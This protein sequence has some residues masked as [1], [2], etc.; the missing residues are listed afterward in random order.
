MSSTAVGAFLDDATR[1]GV[2][3]NSLMVWRGGAVAAEG[4][5]WPYRP[6]L[7]HMMHSATKSFLSAGVG[8]AL[9]EGRFALTDKA[10]SFFDP[11]QLPADVGENLRAMTV[12]DLLTQTSGHSQGASGSVWRFIKTSWV[13]EF[14]KIPVTYRPGAVFKYTSANSFLLSAILSQTTG[15][16]A[17]A[18]ITPRLLEP[19]GIT[20]LSWDVGP[21]GINPGGNG[22]SCRTADL[23]KLAILHLR[24]GVWD[25]RRVL[26]A[27]WVGRATRPQRGNPHGYH[28]W[29]G[30]GGAF[31]AY[32]IF[33][34]FAVAFPEHDAIVV[35]TASAP[36][37][38]ETLRSLIWHHF[39]RAFQT[40]S[41]ASNDEA[42]AERLSGLRVLDPIARRESP[43]AAAISGRRFVAGANDDGMEA[44]RLD[45]SDG[46]CRLEV[47]DERGVHHVD[48][49]LDAW[50]EGETSMTGALLHHGYEPGVQR[51]VAGARWTDDATL[52]LTW[53][54]V[55]TAFRDEVV[56]RFEGDTVT[57]DRTV[58]VNSR[59][60]YRPRISARAAR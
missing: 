42:L 26:P 37:A 7:P 8:L 28:W 47:E 43:T 49:G 4:W 27:D 40:T 13:D 56:L 18:Y 55:E 46:L 3:L 45:F 22:I 51:V 48:M 31:Y 1:L 34:Q 38:E 59:P 41:P 16:N 25:G 20:G 6:E 24:G 52:V 2:E 39:P 30:P 15:G 60:T 10:I 54:F 19:L 29:M 36:P 58:N 35:T 21:E 9:A 33:G 5:W 57:F 32:G 44:F 23:L 53:Q 11:E 17:H 14:F 50:I 12:E